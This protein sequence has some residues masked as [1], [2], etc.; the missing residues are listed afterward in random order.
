MGN[1]SSGFIDHLHQEAITLLLAV[2]DWSVKAD[3]IVRSDHDTVKCFSIVTAAMGLTSL[4]T[5]GVAW[6]LALKACAAGELSEKEVAADEWTPVELTPTSFTVESLPAGFSELVENVEK[7][8]QRIAFLHA[9][10]RG[11]C[12][13]M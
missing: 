6:T 4:V 12:A 8:H 1:V 7:F 2:R 5:D 3:A 9:R 10:Q 11:F 13:P